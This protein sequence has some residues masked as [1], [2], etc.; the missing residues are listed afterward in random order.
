M[1]VKTGIIFGGAGQLGR[2]V[3]TS[4]KDKGW[5]LLSVDVRPNTEADL[6]VLLSTTDKM[7]TQIDK[8]YQEISSF[9]KR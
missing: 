6:N 8:L 9:S 5:K 3:V 2:H 4:F 7:Q 1:K